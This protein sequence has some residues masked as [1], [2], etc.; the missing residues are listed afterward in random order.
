MP[1]VRIN[2]LDGSEMGAYA[3]IPPG[4]NGPGLILIHEVFG[5]NAV[6]RAL[7]DNFAARGYL[8]LCPDLF[9]RQGGTPPEIAQSEP[10]WDTASKLYKNFDLEAGVRDLLASL[11]HIRR[12]TGC[13]GKVGCVGYCLGGRLAYLLSSRS[14]VDCSVGYYGVGLESMLDEIYDIRMPLLLHFGEQDKLIPAPIRTR[15]LAA[16]ARNKIIQSEVY[17]GADHGFARTGSPNYLPEAADLAN[18]KTNAFLAEHL[19]V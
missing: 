13:G 18:K 14:D 8:T 5:I 4:G 11:A 12:M 9:W 6:M 1:E 10:N 3:A 16:L 19:K 7:C 2:T 15:V 17:P